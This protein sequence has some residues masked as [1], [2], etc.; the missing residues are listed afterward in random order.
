MKA[1]RPVSLSL[2]P[3][4]FHWPVNAIASIAHRISGVLLF[5]GVAY[6]L[7]LLD[8]A[9]SSS[10]GF[11][12]AKELVGMTGAK[13]ALIGVL[14]ILAYHML[15]GVKHLL[16]DLHIGGTVVGASRASWLVFSLTALVVVLLGA[17]L[18]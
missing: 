14:T 5:V 7:Y 9:L 18:W 1:E 12:E 6:L 8:M 2:S 4:K 15:A 13:L 11:K 3:A 16:L 10:S 17:W